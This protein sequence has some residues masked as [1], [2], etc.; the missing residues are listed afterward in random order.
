[1]VSTQLVVLGHNVEDH[2]VVL[3]DEVRRSS[4][5]DDEPRGCYLIS[6]SILR[7]PFWLKQVCSILKEKV[8]RAMECCVWYLLCCTLTEA[9]D[10]LPAALLIPVGAHL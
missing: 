1:M 9:I 6:Y 2:G 3:A 4:S 10:A 7:S 5:Q 8:R